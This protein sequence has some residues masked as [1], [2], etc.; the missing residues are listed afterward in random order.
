MPYTDTVDIIKK[1]FS[2]G[3]IMNG[4]ENI[5]LAHTIITNETI[6]LG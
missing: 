5:C 2:K 1:T 3:E 4:I 6:D